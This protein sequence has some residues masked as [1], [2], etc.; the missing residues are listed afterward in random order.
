VR[1]LRLLRQVVRI[2]A[3]PLLKKKKKSLRVNN[4]KK[5]FKTLSF[6]S[7]KDLSAIR[8]SNVFSVPPEGLSRHFLSYQGS[9]GASI[10]G[11]QKNGWI[12]PQNLPR[13]FWG[14]PNHQRKSRL[15]LLS[16][17]IPLSVQLVKLVKIKNPSPATPPFTDSLE[18][19]GLPS[20]R[21]SSTTILRKLLR[22]SILIL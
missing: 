15:S 10:T 14:Y 11:P 13:N 22:T 7:H 19:R 2:P 18:R 17:C 20:S 12:R 5:T 3:F 16:C 6:L 4:L 9:Q 8:V 1:A 21:G